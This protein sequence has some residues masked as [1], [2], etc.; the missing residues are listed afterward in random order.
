MQ[1][2]QG[3]SYR[4]RHRLAAQRLT[5]LILCDGNGSAA[6]KRIYKRTKDDLTNP[7][8]GGDKQRSVYGIQ[9]SVE[10]LGYETEAKERI[11][12]VGLE[13]CRRF[14]ASVVLVSLRRGLGPGSAYLS[15][16]L[17]LSNPMPLL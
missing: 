15:L 6:D 17:S 16:L 13:T 14:L 9:T 2:A 8:M 7:C 10:S 12:P 11:V 1:E 4:T 3:G 5:S